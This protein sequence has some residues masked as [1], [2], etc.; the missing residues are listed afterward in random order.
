M[1]CPLWVH[2]PI[3]LLQLSLSIELIGP[4]GIWIKFHIHD[5]QANL[6]I[7]GWRISCKS[8]H[9]WMSPDFTDVKSTLVQVMAWCRQA[10]SHYL[11]QCWPRPPS[12]YGVT[13]PQGVKVKLPLSKV[14]WAQKSFRYSLDPLQHSQISPNRHNRHPVTCPSTGQDKDSLQWPLLLTWIK[15]NPS[16]DK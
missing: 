7:N 14:S 8:A 10:T 9:K 15:L 5:F 3:Y 4:W 6:V 1:E 16:M 11:C 13:R 2:G 12:P